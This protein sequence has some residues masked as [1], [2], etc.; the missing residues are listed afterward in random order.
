[1][2]AEGLA[3]LAGTSKAQILAYENG[4]R[5]PD[6]ARIRELAKHLGVRPVDLMNREGQ[7]HWDVAAMRRASGMTANELSA[8]LVMSPKSYRRFEQQGIVP[9]RRPRFLDDMVHAL[10]ISHRML[11]AAIDNIPAVVERRWQTGAIITMLAST[12]V[13]RPGAW[14]GPDLADPGV[15]QL[16]TMYGRPAQRIQRILTRLLG[17]LRQMSVRMQREKII[18][19][20]DP[21]PAHQQQAKSAIERWEDV[22]ELEMSRIPARLEG[23]HRSAQP[24]GA[25]QVLV[26]LNDAETRPEGAWVVASLLGRLETMEQLPPSLVTQTEFDG[27]PAARLT[28][29]GHSHVRNFQELYI[30]LYPGLRRPRPKTKLGSSGSRPP[31]S[32]TLPGN[33]ER[34]VVPPSTIERLLLTSKGSGPWDMWI[35]PN[36]RLTLNT[37]GG[38]PAAAAQEDAAPGRTL[39]F[40]PATQV[41]KRPDE[42]TSEA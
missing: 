41:A 21:E 24:S 4:H 35:S 29:A 31:V 7:R 5:T 27:I 39:L 13:H 37:A 30:A 23:F 38:R 34:F 17:E 1:M 25:W 2:T 26:D 22:Y 16:S 36:V 18:A 33:Q 3:K 11:H 19:D 32:F 20:F 9:A 40:D 15:V 28:T 42:T 8:E 6:P 12:Y 14:K 10:L